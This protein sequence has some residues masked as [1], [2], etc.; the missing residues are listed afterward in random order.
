MGGTGGAGGAGGLGVCASVTCTAA[1]QCHDVGTCDP[2]TGQCSNPP[3]TDGT[4]CTDS[5]ACTRSDTCQT[6]YP[7][8]DPRR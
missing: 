7:L 1:D 4:L 3:K 5:N 8:G 2:A 6:G